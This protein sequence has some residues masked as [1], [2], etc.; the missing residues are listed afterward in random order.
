MV[1]ILEVVALVLEEKERVFVEVVIYGRES[2]R[3][4]ALYLDSF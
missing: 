2:E 4:A 1:S 3:I